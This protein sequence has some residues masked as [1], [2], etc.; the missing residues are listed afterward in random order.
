MLT[1]SYFGEEAPASHSLS[2]CL[3][4]PLRT[5]FLFQGARVSLQYSPTSFPCASHTKVH[6]TK[7]IPSK[8]T[9]WFF[10]SSCGTDSA[11][12]KAASTVASP[13]LGQELQ[14]LERLIGATTREELPE[15]VQVLPPRFLRDSAGTTVRGKGMDCG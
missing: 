12:T 13:S 1:A 5:L 14:R 9:E 15:V 10:S 8:N 4:D 7:S 11:T 3:R 6:E 2:L